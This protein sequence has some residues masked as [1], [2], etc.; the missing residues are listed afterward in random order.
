[1]YCLLAYLLCI[2][3]SLENYFIALV[4]TIKYYLNIIFKCLHDD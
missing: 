4:L 3:D 1:M 2:I